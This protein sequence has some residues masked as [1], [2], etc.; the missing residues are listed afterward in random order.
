MF[1]CL[2]TRAVHIEVVDEMSSAAFINALR[3]FVALRGKVKVFRSDRGT[4]FIGA[5]DDLRIDT[6][7]VEDGPVKNYLYNSGTVWIFNP[8]HASHMGGV[9]ERMI[10]VTRKILDSMMSN[11]SGRTFT[12]DVLCTFM[13]EVCAIINNRPIVPV[14]TDPESPFVLSPATLLTQ[15]TNT[16][17]PESI[18]GDFSVKDLYKSSWRRVQALADMFLARW[19][20]EYL[21]VLQTRRKWCDARR[22]FEP[23]DVVILRDK[24]VA[25][26]QWPLGVVVNAFKSL[27]NYVRKVEVRIMKDGKPCVYTR[28]ISEL[29]LVVPQ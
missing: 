25:R 7:N 22:N 6:I 14:S 15:K 26:S 11:A 9:W 8:P 16:D 20:K 23:G 1:T 21:H 5:T 19:R 13:A 24:S 18:V 28:P 12:H 17:Y 3:R 27:D 4:N 29:A 2:V 10:G